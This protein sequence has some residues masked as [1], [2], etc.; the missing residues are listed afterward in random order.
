M[1]WT[2]EASS[3]ARAHS[4]TLPCSYSSRSDEMARRDNLVSLRKPTSAVLGLIGVRIV[5]EHANQA[6]RSMA[7]SSIDYSTSFQHAANYRSGSR[8]AFDRICLLRLHAV[9]AG[10]DRVL[11]IRTPQRFVSDFGRPTQS[12]DLASRKN[13]RSEAQLSADAFTVIMVIETLLRRE[14]KNEYMNPQTFFT[15][16]MTYLYLRTI[17]FPLR[18][19]HACSSVGKRVVLFNS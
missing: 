1:V 6:D 11:C 3:E 4:R 9:P 16:M 7:A 8:V 12:S 18:H 17:T 13:S 10:V 5:T 15:G 14:F 2:T 19:M